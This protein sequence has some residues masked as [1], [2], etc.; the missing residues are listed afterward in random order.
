MPIYFYTAKSL[1]GEIKT[2]NLEAK[3][4]HGLAETLHQQG[5]VLIKAV[6]EE[7]QTRKRKFEITIPFLGRVS[8][9]DKMMF[10][11]NLQVMV[12]SGLPLPRSLGVL[13][14]QA[15]NKKL[16]EVLLGVREEITKGNSFSDSLA[17][18]PHIFSEL[19]VNM[20]KVGEETGNLDEIL[21]VLAH[22]M[23]K[24]HE[25]KSKI[26]GAMVYPA[27]IISAM[28]GIGVL[29]LIMVVPKLAQTFEELN[30]ELPISTRFVIGLGTFLAEKWY[31]LPLI[32]I[33]FFFVLAQIS[34]TKKGKKTIDS[35]VL[36]APVIAPIIKNT[37]SAYTTRT[38]SSL[39]SSGVPIVRSLEILSRT[40]GNYYFK[41]AIMQAAEKVRKGGKLSEALSPYEGLYPLIVLQMIEVG[42]ET[43]ETSSILAKLADFFEE[44]V[45]NSTKNLAAVIEPVLMLLV[46]GAVGF[47]AISMIQPMYSMLGAI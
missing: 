13:S 6:L 14:N 38:L 40:L 3:D 18:Y 10:T 1:N 46:G 7:E 32:I 20:I 42:E 11:R 9:T 2:G 15:K 22:Q 26:K 23:E 19:F 21:K 25:L 28:L 37:N 35:F 24:S 34:K 8:L 47:F 41:E 36:K 43:G 27:V 17:K 30:V 33:G 5:Y 45:S 4:K 29:M 12:S 39:L 31:L 16:K 44:E